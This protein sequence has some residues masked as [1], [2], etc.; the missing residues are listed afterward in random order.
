MIVVQ[1]MGGLGNQMFQYAAALGLALK[2]G[3]QIAF[4]LEKLFNPTREET[5]RAFLLDHFNLNIPILSK[6]DIETIKK[7]SSPTFFNKVSKR[8]GLNES[9]YH[10]YSEPRS[11]AYSSAFLDLPSNT[12][13][14]NS[15]FQHLDYI[16]NCGEKIH[17]SFGIAHRQPISGENKVAVHIRRGDYVTSQAAAHYH[18]TCSLRYYQDAITRVKSSINDPTFVFFSDDISWVKQN[19]T[20]PDNSLFPQSSS[21]VGDFD[22]MRQCDHQIIANSSFS[23]WAAWLNRNEHK[24]VIAPKKW[25]NDKTVDTSGLLPKEWI[26]L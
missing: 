23:W 26:T 11:N 15:Y 13:L 24:M 8:I 12:Y 18:G 7:K 16:I 9:F 25:V 14:L 1:L 20:I 21:D 19:L 5:P 17:K 10:F 22:L 3:T 4:D 6:Q 2:N